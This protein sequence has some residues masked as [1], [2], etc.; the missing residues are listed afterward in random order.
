MPSLEELKIPSQF[1]FEGENLKRQATQKTI[2]LKALLTVPLQKPL[3]YQR[4]TL[5]LKD[6]PLLT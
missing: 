6:G 1:L 4:K 3:H 5:A 2:R